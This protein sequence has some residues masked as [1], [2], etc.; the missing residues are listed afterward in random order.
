M[1]VVR[2][3]NN[4]ATMNIAWKVFES[5]KNILF[6]QSLL[7]TI[8][9]TPQNTQFLLFDDF[10]ID[11]FKQIFVFILVH[12]LMN[13]TILLIY[14]GWPRTL[15]ICIQVLIIFTYRPLVKK[16]KLYTEVVITDKCTKEKFH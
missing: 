8:L 16:K 10:K 4:G 5:K 6:N 1:T 14:I 2:L 11:F 12:L 7:K 13:E 15:I 9:Y 3:V